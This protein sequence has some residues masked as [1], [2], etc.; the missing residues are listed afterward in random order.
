[1]WNQIQCNYFHWQPSYSWTATLNFTRSVILGTSDGRMIWSY[2]QYLSAQQIW[3]IMFI[4]NRDMAEKPNPRWRPTS[5]VIFNQ[6]YFRPSVTFVWAVC[7]CRQ[8]LVQIGQEVAE[9]HLFMYFQD[10]GRRLLE[11]YQNY[12]TGLVFIC[13]P[14]FMQISALATE[15]WPEI[16]WILTKCDVGSQQTLYAYEIWRK[17][18]HKRSEY[19]RKNDIQDGG[20]RHLEFPATA[21]WIPW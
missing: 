7:I 6:C 5:S 21:T 18:L 19:S 17:Y 10:G 9:I 15:I 12:G 14:N 11:F 8:N 16:Q 1:M 3:R 4:G 2:D 13:V 20:R